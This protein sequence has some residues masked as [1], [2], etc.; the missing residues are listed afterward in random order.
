VSRRDYAGGAQPTTSTRLFTAADSTLAVVS[1]IGWPD[2]QQGPFAVCVDRDTPF[3]EKILCDTINGNDLNVIQRGYDGTT[4][5]DHSAGA[6]VE[7]V[8]TS[9]DAEE[10]NEHVNSGSGVHGI[11]VGAQIVGTSG[12][13]TLTDKTIDGGPASG[14]TITNLP[15]T[16]MPEAAQAITA[17]VSAR[18]AGDAARYTKTEV[19]ALLAAIRA[20]ATKNDPVGVVKVYAGTASSVPQGWL[21]CDG[22]IVTKDAYP[23]LFAAIGT[24]YGGNGAPN[25]NLPNIVGREV[26]GAGAGN[27]LGVTGGADSVTLTD[28][29]LPSHSHS[30]DH[31]HAPVSTAS[32][33]G[34]HAHNVPA[35]RDIG[36]DST[37][38]QRVG[39][40]DSGTAYN[41]LSTST[42]GAH[43]HNVDLPNFVGTS[44]PAGSGTAFDA[45]DPFINLH[46]IIRVA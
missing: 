45:R 30:I 38:G 40:Q 18:A 46:Y 3:E 16:S 13:Q 31:D 4:A 44:G 22:R 19:D 27:D 15:L 8:F 39:A 11:P 6:K 29:N 1:L 12:Q 9:I 34:N 35:Q 5:R 33:G 25:F 14:N 43:Q 42:D 41:T 26:R 2:G 37:G 28:A 7:H 21:P 10:A 17:E 32:G 20:D 24:T 36:S 23:A